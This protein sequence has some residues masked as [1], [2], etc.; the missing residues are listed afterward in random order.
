MIQVMDQQTKEPWERTVI[1]REL[2]ARPEIPDRTRQAVLVD[3]ESM[4]AKRKSL[5]ESQGL[6]HWHKHAPQRVERLLRLIAFR[7]REDIGRFLEQTMEHALAVA[8]RICGRL[9]DAEDIVSEANYLVWR[10]ELDQAEYLS[11]VKK[12]AGRIL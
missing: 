9:T 3:I 2:L 10:G 7:R 6:N 4:L 5:R 11:W 8:H 12:R 1:L